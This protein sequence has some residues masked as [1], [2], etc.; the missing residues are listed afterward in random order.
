MRMLASSVS[1]I[2]LSLSIASVA[3]SEDAPVSPAAR[4]LAVLASLPAPSEKG[5]FK[6]ECNLY[7]G[8]MVVGQ[9]TFEAKV[10]VVDKSP[11][12]LVEESL[13]ADAGGGR[14]V[15]QSKAA[16]L[17]ADLRLLRLEATDAQGDAKKSTT[18][19][20][21][22]TGFNLTKVGPDGTAES[23]LEADAHTIGT[24]TAVLV[25]LRHCPAEAASYELRA[26]SADSGVV[27]G[28]T[29][30]VKGLGKYTEGRVSVD[31]FVTH[32]VLGERVMDV[33]L[34]PTNREFL[35]IRSSAGLSAVKAG[36]LD[37]DTSAPTASAVEAGSRF[38]LAILTSD[39][40]L[41]SSAIHWPS[42]WSVAKAI[43]GY[44]DDEAAYKV[45]AMS[46]LKPTFKTLGRTQASALVAKAASG[47]K[48]DVAG[49]AT[50]VTFGAPMVGFVYTAK[51]IDD[52]WYIVKL[53][54]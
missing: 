35:A 3:R 33:Y 51:A 11:V 24:M 14:Q 22:E 38:A 25:F 16:T 9:A 20:R 54:K 7:S 21:T 23:K 32:A 19:I 28:G 15:I 40:A 12:W 29:L 34:D 48:E 30:D 46:E 52:V 6:F 37:M 41:L 45:K 39:E 44:T 50:I 4:G 26:F 2:A 17:G 18:A 43:E 27:E 5:A 1:V 8:G 36:L 49:E 42:L 47:A 10:G 13:R 53:S 31:A